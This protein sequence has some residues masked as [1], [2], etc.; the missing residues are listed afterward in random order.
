MIELILKKI[1]RKIR[2]LYN[3]FKKSI[4]Y[5]FSY[6]RW[7]YRINFGRR[8][9][10]PDNMLKATVIINS[11]NR[12]KNIG[13]MVQAALMCDFVEKVIVSNNNPQVRIENWVKA[14]DDRVQLIQHKFRKRCRYRWIIAAK[15][16]R[17]YYIAIDD[18]V[19]VYPEQLK[20]LFEALIDDPSV[21]HGMF[22]SVYI[23]GDPSSDEFSSAYSYINSRNMSVDVLHQIYAVTNDHVSN[24][25]DLLAKIRINNREVSNFLRKI[26]DDIIMSHAGS[27]RP[28]THD[29]GFVL[30]CPSHNRAGLATFQDLEF[31]QRR[32]KIFREARRTVL[33][34]RWTNKAE[35]N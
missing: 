28:K 15:N 24:Y 9:D 27:E 29:F 10:L 22:G 31:S 2:Y 12:E 18:D 5:I 32:L 14:S 6:W 19:F 1:G 8:V 21:P 30:E 17:R 7:R 20:K 23:S 35:L 34:Y 11:Y 3:K 4:N 13:P 16:P 26:G 33:R 25:F